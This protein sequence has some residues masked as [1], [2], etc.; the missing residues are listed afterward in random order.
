MN[1]V[2]QS[3]LPKNQLRKLKW[4]SSTHINNSVISAFPITGVLELGAGLNSTPLFFDKVPHVISVE[5]DLNWITKLR[6]TISETTNQRIVHH[7]LPDTITRATPRKQIPSNIKN[8]ALVLYRSVM[9]EHLN[10]LFV[11]CYGGFRLSA[12]TELYHDFDV[13]A[14]HDAEPN[15]DKYYG[16]SEF[17]SG[18]DFYH[19]TDK[20]FLVHTGILIS[21]KLADFLPTFKQTLEVK[22]QEYANKFGVTHKFTLVEH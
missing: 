16:Y 18:D 11:D 1:H 2:D 12:M 20:T 5:A 19:L 3:R 14:Y 13:I 22:A 8:N 4:G 15:M 9:N 7:R 10:Y 6:E 17:Q 21:K